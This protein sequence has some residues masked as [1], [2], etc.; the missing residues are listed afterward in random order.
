MSSEATVQEKDL[1]TPE[2]VCSELQISGATLK[3]MVYSD[4]IGRIHIFGK[5][6]RYRRSDVDRI[7]KGL[8]ART[9]DDTGY[10]HPVGNYQGNKLRAAR[11]AAKAAEKT[12]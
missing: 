6:Y 9:L 7:K 1:M 5:I 8:L 11:E 12:A 10:L 4:R 2:Q 3:N